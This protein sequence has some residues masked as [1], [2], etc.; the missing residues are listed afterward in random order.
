MLSSTLLSMLPST[1][2]RGKT[3]PISLDYMLPCMLLG[4]WSRYL[5]SCR[6][7]ALVGGWR[8]AEIITS[9]DIIVWTL[10]SAWPPWQDF[11]DASRSWCSQLQSEILQE[12]QTIESGGEQ[13]SDSHFPKE[14]A[15]RFPPIVG[16]CVHIWLGADGDG[17]DGDESHGDGVGDGNYSTRCT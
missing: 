16:V 14:S 10:F 13:I 15:A 8:V 11:H 7:Q 4:A 1:L 17:G 3:L 5:L 9:V 2:S 6:G 12:R